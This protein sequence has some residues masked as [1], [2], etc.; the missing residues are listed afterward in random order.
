MSSPL[1]NFNIALENL[2][3]EID[4]IKEVIERNKAASDD[5]KPVVNQYKRLAEDRR[6]LQKDLKD[7]EQQLEVIMNFIKAATGEETYAIF[8]LFNQQ[9][10]KQQ[11]GATA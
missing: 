10:I 8:P 1:H 4:E 6:D 2:K 7:K 9:N 5:I 11:Q 3:A